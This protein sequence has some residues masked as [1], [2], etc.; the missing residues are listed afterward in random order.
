VRRGRRFERFKNSLIDSI[1]QNRLMQEQENNSSPTGFNRRDFISNAASFSALMALMGGVPLHA[2]VATNAPAGAPSTGYSTVSAPLN[3]G[4]IGC[5]PWGREVLQTLALLPNAPVVAVCDSYE[6]MLRRATAAAPKA[7]SFTDYRQLLASKD[8]QGVVVATPTH[9]HREIVEA[10]LAAGKHVYCEAPLANTAEDARAIARA[11]KAAVKVNFQAGLQMRSDPQ[12]HFLLPF[13]RSGAAGTNVMARSQ[14]HKKESWRRPASNPE[15]ELA[16][17]WRLNSATS[18]GLIG[19][20]VIHQLDMIRWLANT[21]P[22]AVSGWG[23]ILGWK[24]GRDVADT[25]QAVFEFP[26][27]FNYS[28]DAS[29]ANSFDSSYEI[30]YGT[31]SAVMMRVTVED[32]SKAWLFKEVDSPLLGWEVYARKEQFYKETGIALIANASKLPPAPKPGE[33][34]PPQPTPL[35]H[36]LANFI[37]NSGIVGKGIEDFI[38]NYGADDLDGMREYITGPTITSSRRSAAGWQEG[39]EATLA[40]IQANDAIRK[41]HGHRV[42]FEKGSL[43]L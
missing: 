31:F 13:I 5:G 29:L 34:R 26:D 23:S 43:E 37:S 9:L 14:W 1:I 16:V 24:D 12:R 25:I 17:N 15:R 10:A 41:G 7:Q 30:L 42:V 36:S 8:V 21:K 33:P 32:G 28:A 39:L 4:V 2:E 19:E 20:N 18:L 11:A 3:F 22:V 6:P 35:Q 40:V 27:G 38:A